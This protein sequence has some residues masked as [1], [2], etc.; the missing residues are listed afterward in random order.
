M[1]IAAIWGSTET[2]HIKASHPHF[3][4]G[5]QREDFREGGK[6]QKIGV[7][8]APFAI[9]LLF[10]CGSSLLNPTQTAN[11]EIFAGS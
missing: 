8:R 7:V 1:A 11:S 10:F 6:S 9:I 2:S 5:F 4:G 3:L